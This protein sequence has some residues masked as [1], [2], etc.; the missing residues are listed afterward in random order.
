MEQENALYC[1]SHKRLLNWTQ[2]RYRRTDENH[3][4]FD[5]QVVQSKGIDLCPFTISVGHMKDMIVI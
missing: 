4:A 5:E 3:L 2:V 1:E